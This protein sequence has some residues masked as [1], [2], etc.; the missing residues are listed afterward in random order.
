MEERL[1]ITRIGD[2]ELKSNVLYGYETRTIQVKPYGEVW[3]KKYLNSLVKKVGE[4]KVLDTTKTT[5][6]SKNSEKSS[7]YLLLGYH[8]IFPGDLYDNKTI[9]IDELKVENIS[10]VLTY[11]QI[12]DVVKIEENIY[13]FTLKSIDRYE[14]ESII[15][16][17][18]ESGISADKILIKDIIR[19]SAKRFP[20]VL[21]DEEIPQTE[22]AISRIEEALTALAKSS[23]WPK[24][25]QQMLLSNPWND[26]YKQ[27]LSEGYKTAKSENVDDELPT[28]FEAISQLIRYSFANNLTKL[29]IIEAK[30]Y[31]QQA[32][33]LTNQIIWFY[34]LMEWSPKEE[35]VFRSI[36][37]FKEALSED[38]EM[39]EIAEA[40]SLNPKSS[41]K[42]KKSTDPIS[43]AIVENE[44]NKKVKDNLEKQQ[45]EFLLKEKLK[46][47]KETLQEESNND[48]DDSEFAKNSKDKIKAKIY[49][50]SVVKLIKSETNKLKS[51]MS[52]SPDA[53]ITSSYVNVLKS[54]PW[55]KVE[56]ETLDINKA[57]EI[58]DKNH[59]GLG[60]VKERIIE[61]LSLIINHKNI[62]K[63]SKKDVLLNFDD[64][65]QIDL[66]LFKEEDQ[67]AKVQKNFNN[68]P[69]L[70]LVGPPGTGKTSLA[71]AIAEALNKSYIKISLGG[72][73]DESEI[74][75]H[76]RTY[77]GA[78]PGKI[79]KAIQKTGVSNPLILLDEIDKMSSDYKGD[80]SSAM[81]EVLDPEQ[82]T[83][84][85]DNY[86]EHEYDLSKVMFIA[87]ANYYENI[88]KPLLDRV[89]IIELHSYTTNEK[90]KIAREHLIDIA[91]RQ[92]GLTKDQFIIEDDVIEAIIKHYTTEAGVRGLKRQFDKI[93]R[94]I[95]TKIVAG[96]NI[97]EFKIDK[98]T[99][100]KLLGTPKF[101]GEDKI[102]KPQIGVVNGLAYT[103]IGGST[104]QIEVI[105]YLNKNGG[106][107]LTG[108][109]KDVMKESAS[110]AYSFVRSNA[111]NF[112]IE[113]EFES[114]EIHIHVP[115]GAVPKDGPSAGVT[116]TTALISALTQKPVSQ[117][118]A[119]TGEITLRGR[120]LE[121]GGLKEKSF[122]AFKN[123]IKTVFIPKS[124][125]KNLKDIPE[126]VLN[127]IQ[128]VPVEHYQE[129]FDHLF[130]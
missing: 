35:V 18:D 27:N 63:N 38:G 34:S 32:E 125:E 4:G 94:K 87:T 9:P 54:L 47:I 82:N 39:D 83:K 59:Y 90:I 124:N 91:I 12:L 106:F 16:L 67:N 64:N 13:E 24:I 20:L 123:G 104:L 53:N 81:L 46:V 33:I 17:P 57:R 58:L 66:E 36:A 88:P 75:G 95:V 50:D 126:E 62:A 51:M 23:V 74:R 44:L 43:D 37:L 108:S 109:L 56:V 80:P 71:R 25:E 31:L 129:I 68:V 61:Y 28:Y 26:L 120:V 60:E 119:M 84:F 85:Q 42:G 11:A 118:V 21:P 89:E 41:K 103:S 128:F 114:N 15:T 97:K 79:I 30:T 100:F 116:F 6:K 111:K 65:H 110:I 72:V 96:E 69:I 29:K 102:G 92:S 55:R 107:K 98:E 40:T 22:I 19:V 2:P 48:E 130:K 115:E 112:G 49:P 73:H 7:E 122:A 52:G 10:S 45:R 70:T 101:S 78:M 8:P 3:T 77:V 99:A 117:D 113:F 105:P 127:A 93:A 1:L 76:R 14:L 121:I 5:S 86:L